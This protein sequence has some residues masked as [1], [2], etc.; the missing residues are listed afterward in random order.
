[1]LGY[2]G[3]AKSV[4]RINKTASS[5]LELPEQGLD[6]ILKEVWKSSRKSYK[7]DK[8]LTGSSIIDEPLQEVS[9]SSRSTL[10]W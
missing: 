10:F 7:M 8:R 3:Y 2:F 5:T 1:M 4:E 6:G 9:K